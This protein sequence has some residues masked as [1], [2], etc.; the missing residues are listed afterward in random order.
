[1][2]RE[3]KKEYPEVDYKVQFGLC[4]S[5][6]LS[7]KKE[8]EKKDKKATW[9]DVEKSCEE[10][11][12]DLGMTDF[13]VNEWKKYDK[14]R[15]YIE[16]RYYRKGKCKERVSCGYWDDITEEY[17]PENRYKRQYDVLNKEYV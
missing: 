1:M 5:Y 17:V 3:I 13:Y 14:V 16:L 15:Y 12:E 10:A 2:A 11:V 8:E 9:K 6:L 7:E 4:L